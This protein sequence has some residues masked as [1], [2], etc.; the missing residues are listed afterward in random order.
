[1]GGSVSAVVVEEADVVTETGLTSDSDE[2]P[3]GEHA[4]RNPI[5]PAPAMTAAR[6]RPEEP[7]CVSIRQ[8]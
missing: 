4:D 5:S 2:D 7:N 6:R 1:M 8:C 3:F